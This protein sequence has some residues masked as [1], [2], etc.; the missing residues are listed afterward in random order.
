MPGIHK[1]K[2]YS[3]ASL[4]KS[5]QLIVTMADDAE[6]IKAEKVAAA[7]KRVCLR[8]GVAET[9]RE[10]VSQYNADGLRLY[11][12]CSAPEEEEGWEKSC[13]RI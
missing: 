9:C 1:I 2:R 8:L 6:R 3:I 12:G 5:G 10:S 7:R 4:L 11:I 13:C